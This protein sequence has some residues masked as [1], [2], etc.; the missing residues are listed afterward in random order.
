[1]TTA[2]TVKSASKVLKTLKL[3][4]GHSLS[5]ACVKE[6][7]EQL[8]ETPSQTHRFLQTLV[9][10][11]FAETDGK[12]SYKLGTALLQIANAHHRE[13]ERAKARIAEVEQRSSIAIY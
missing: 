7:S 13:I 10:E 9:D 4:R 1:M 12:G 5:G 6:L 3:L 2:S 8:D 11:G